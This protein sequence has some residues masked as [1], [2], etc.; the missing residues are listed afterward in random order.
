MR[1]PSRNSGGPLAG[2]DAS[3]TRARAGLH[4][5]LA[6]A[7]VASEQPA[8]S[9]AELREAGMLAIRI[10]SARQRRRIRHLESILG[11]S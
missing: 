10:G 6:H 5:D 4:V 1:P 11:A 2:L 7:L 9:T 8:E 3:F